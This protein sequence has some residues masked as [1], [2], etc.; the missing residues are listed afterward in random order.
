M[1]KVLFFTLSIILSVIPA[2]AY[3]IYE[4]KEE[5]PLTKGV[6]YIHMKVL[7]DAGWNN[8]SIL[9]ADRDAF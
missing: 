4:S 8:Y 1:K 9:K 2:Y 7:T 5:T 3:T 6:S